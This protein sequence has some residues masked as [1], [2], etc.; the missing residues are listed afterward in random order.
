MLCYTA[1]SAISG[2]DDDDDDNATESCLH[3]ET[4]LSINRVYTSRDPTVQLG[5]D[6]SAAYLHVVKP[7][8]A[9]CMCITCTV[10]Q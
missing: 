10:V 7:S 9:R 2:D 1:F 4:L 6:R 3:G 8:D 5:G